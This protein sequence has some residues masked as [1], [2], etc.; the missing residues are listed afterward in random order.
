MNIFD[1]GENAVF[2]GTWKAALFLLPTI[3]ILTVFLYFPA[4]HSLVMSFFRNNLFLGTHTFIGLENYRNLFTGP[5][6]PA[7]LQSLIQTLLISLLIVFIGISA[8]IFL[9]IQANKR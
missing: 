1:Q 8:S 5:L 6:A 7:F 4:W 2:K 9:A 3:L